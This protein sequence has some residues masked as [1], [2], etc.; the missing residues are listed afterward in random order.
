MKPPPLP[1]RIKGLLGIYRV[2]VGTQDQSNAGECVITERG[3]EIR[4]TSALPPMLQWQALVHELVHKWEFEGGFVLKDTPGDSDV[5]RLAMAITA[6]FIRNGW[7]L[8]GG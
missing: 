1:K 6:D 3:A 5:D 8:P 2:V 7:V 4:V